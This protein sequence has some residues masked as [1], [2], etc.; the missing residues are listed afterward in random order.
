MGET[1]LDE[2]GHRGGCLVAVELAVGVA[3]VVVDERVHPLE[4]DPQPPLGTAAVAVASDGMTGTCEADE[5]FAVDMQQVTGTGPLVATRPRARLLGPPRD[6]LPLER[7]PD[8]RPLAAAAGCG[9]AVTNDP[10]DRQ[11]TAA[12]PASP[13]TNAATTY[14]PSSA[15]RRGVS[16]PPYTNSPTRYPRP[17]HDDQQVRDAR[18]GEAPSGSHLRL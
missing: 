6:P 18:Y 12:A 17:A 14:K 9:A 4:T 1:A 11:A 13:Q 10:R 5:A 3:G 8:G 16:P 7:P 15:K 2:A